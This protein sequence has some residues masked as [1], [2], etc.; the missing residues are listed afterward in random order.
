MI[1]LLNN[2]EDMLLLERKEDETANNNNDPYSTADLTSDSELVFSPS[3][4]Q[5]QRKDS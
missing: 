3:R 1:E 5:Q 2:N 4:K